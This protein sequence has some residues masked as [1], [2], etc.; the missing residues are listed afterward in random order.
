MPEMDGFEATRAIRLAEG[1]PGA[2]RRMPIVALTAN[3]VKGDRDR[4]LAA[5]MDTYLTKPVNRQQLEECVRAIL[6]RDNETRAGIGVNAK[7]VE[8]E[9]IA[10]PAATGPAPPIDAAALSETLVGDVEL[11]IKLIEKFEQTIAIEW[12]KIEAALCSGDLKQV[13][14]SAHT[15]KGTAA[16]MAA[17]RIVEAA[18]AVEMQPDLSSE[19]TIREQLAVLRLETDRCL[20]YLPELR[21]QFAAQSV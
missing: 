12:D 20:E 18:A 11:I 7:P 1:Q 19:G 10:E 15:L 16:Y 6:A 14:R 13:S 8:E 9:A 3:A 5:G 17:P 21:E 2:G 4:C